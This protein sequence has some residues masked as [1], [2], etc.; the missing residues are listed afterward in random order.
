MEFSSAGAN[1]RPVMVLQVLILT[2]VTA[3]SAPAGMVLVEAPDAA[4]PSSYRQKAEEAMARGKTIPGAWSA[5]VKRIFRN[6]T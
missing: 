1:V 4:A 2:S 5:H 3:G 6:C